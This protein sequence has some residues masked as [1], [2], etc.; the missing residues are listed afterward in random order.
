MFNLAAMLFAGQGLT[1][2]ASRLL[3]TFARDRGL[4]PLSP[5]LATVHS[6]LKVPVW[7]VVF[8]SAW[9]TVFG[10]I[11][12]GSSIALNAILS[13]SV[14]F[15]QISYAVPIAL[16]FVRGETAFEGRD[17]GHK[18]SL[19]RWRRPVNG[20]ALVFLLVTTVTFIL[21]P[22]IPVLSGT[23]MN[24]VVLVGGIVWVMCGLT[25]VVDG[26]KRFFG[27]SELEE[28]LAVGK[29]A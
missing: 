11:N 16:M 27:P 6:T 13:A 5:Y 9:V 2:V 3:L 20:A 4:G 18:W 24:W 21:P 15:L 28:R 23:S 12:L 14:V 10:M 1:T 19:G 25:W 7:C 26:R 22:F 29:A 8:V 17:K